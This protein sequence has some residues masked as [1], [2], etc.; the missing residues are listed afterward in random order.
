MFTA[1]HIFEPE[2]PYDFDESA[3]F[4][5]Y[6]RGRYAADSLA[7]GVFSRALDIG[8]K[9]VALSVRSVGE[10]ERPRIE[11]RLGRRPA[12]H[13]RRSRKPWGWR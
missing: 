4:A 1:T 13:L 12:E 6:G 3:G 10:V 7:D 2:P 5:M 9:T 11:V 8:G